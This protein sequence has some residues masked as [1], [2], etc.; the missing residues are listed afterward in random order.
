MGVWRGVGRR[1][2]VCAKNR[3]VV[4]TVNIAVPQMLETLD[5]LMPSI[6]QEREHNSVEE[7]TLTITVPEIPEQISKMVQLMEKTIELPQLQTVEKKVEIP[8]AQMVQGAQT[9]DSA[10]DENNCGHDRNATSKQSYGGDGIDDAN[11]ENG[12]GHESD[13]TSDKRHQ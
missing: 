10:R 6:P 5:T 9:V 8:E 4:Q 12:R 3:T 2:V 13:A 7:H 1:G 11:D